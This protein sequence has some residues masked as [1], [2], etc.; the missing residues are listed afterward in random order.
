MYAAS[1][2]MHTFLPILCVSVFLNLINEKKILTSKLCLKLHILLKSHT[3]AN[4]LE[5][6]QKYNL[7]RRHKMFFKGVLV[8]E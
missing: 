2:F 4:N 6:L 1:I 3:K 8:S 5:V 7:L